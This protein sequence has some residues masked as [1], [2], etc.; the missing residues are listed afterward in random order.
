MKVPALIDELQE[1][2]YYAADVTWHARRPGRTIAF[3]SIRKPVK[4]AALHRGRVDS[5]R[6]GRKADTS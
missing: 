3:W 2:G 4:L 6:A 5:A 1:S